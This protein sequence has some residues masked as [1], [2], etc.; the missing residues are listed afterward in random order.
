M[1]R[2]SMKDSE[3]SGTMLGDAGIAD[4]HHYPVPK[5]KKVQYQERFLLLSGI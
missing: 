2:Q 5:L 4:V 3:G 1:N